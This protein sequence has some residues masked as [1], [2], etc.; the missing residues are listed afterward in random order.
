MTTMFTTPIKTTQ[1]DL[2]L[3]GG[4]GRSLARMSCAD[5]DV[6]GGF[7]VTTDA[8]KK[9]IADSDLKSKII[10]LAKPELRDGYPNFELSSKEINKI[11]QNAKIDANITDQIKVAYQQLDQANLSVAVRSSANAEDLP[12]FSFAG[13]QETFLNVSGEDEVVSAVKKCWSSLWTAQAISYSCL[14]YTSP[15]PRD[16]SLSRMPSSA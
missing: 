14:L 3:V 16:R 7:L 9:F 15:S 10:E 5:F 1:N 13:Q 8:Y 4:K 2:D 6:P 12:D 11:I